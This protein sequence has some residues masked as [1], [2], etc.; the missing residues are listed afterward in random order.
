MTVNSSHPLNGNSKEKKTGNGV[1]VIHPTTNTPIS[2]NANT[3]PASTTSTS[4][5][6]S[7]TTTT[8]LDPSF[9]MG[10]T[11]KEGEEVNPNGGQRRGKR[12]AGRGRTTAKKIL[13]I[14]PDRIL[15]DP[16]TTLMIRNIPNRYGI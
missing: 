6:S 16:R 8:V 5:A 9:C 7:M 1:V 2:A 13:T 4:T 14:D 15:S 11:A 3:T 12:R 10:R